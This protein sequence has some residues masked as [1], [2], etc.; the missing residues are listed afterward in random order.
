MNE[1]EDTTYWNCE[2][3]VKQYLE[4]FRAVNIYIKIKISII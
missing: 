3:Q 1:N 4:E 2:M